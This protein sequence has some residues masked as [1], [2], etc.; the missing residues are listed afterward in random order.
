MARLSRS[1]R[2][3]RVMA[4]LDE[5]ASWLEEAQVA[6]E[7][8]EKE[9]EIDVSALDEPMGEVLNL[10]EE[11]EAWR[12]SWEGTNLECTHKFE[13]LE[14]AIDALQEIEDKLQDVVSVLDNEPGENEVEEALDLVQTAAD[15]LGDVEW[16]RMF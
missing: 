15:E 5:F 6:I 16:P 1:K 10:R 7:S 3:S 4:G 8:G 2:A 12:D 13:A 14:E 11:L 9:V